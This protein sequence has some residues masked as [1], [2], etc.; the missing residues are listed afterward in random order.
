MNAT[1]LYIHVPFCSGKCSYCDFFSVPFRSDLGQVYL[2]ALDRE[3]QLV[4]DQFFG[5]QK[6]PVET[7]YLGGGTP[8]SLG[9]HDLAEL[10]RIIR[11]H[12]VP[13][14]ECEFTSEA[15]P[16]S[17]TTGKVR[18]LKAAGMNRLSIGAQTF[19]DAL[20][21]AIGR[22]HTSQQTLWAM[23]FA[24]EQEIGNVSLDLIYALPGQSREQFVN[25]LEIAVRLMPE[26]L[27][28]YELTYEPD[29][30]LAR[31]RAQTGEPEEE[32]RPVEM[33]CLADSRLAAAGFE[34]YEISNYAKPGFQC[35]HNLRY[36]QNLDYIGLGP[37]AAGF[38]N[39]RRY[40][41]TG[42]LGAYGDRLLKDNR[43][44]VASDEVLSARA[45][46]GE[47]AMLALRTRSGIGRQ[48]FLNRTGCDPFELFKA[49]I[50]KYAALGLLEVHA[51]RITLTMKGWT[52][53]NEV[54]ADF[55]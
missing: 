26:H 7:I 40:K 2:R 38:L 46:A 4:R 34:H 15:N 32:D 20:L 55:L 49:P 36:W 33:F 27:S 47:T 35:R 14:A 30:K 53:S 9:L 19:D 16:E 3:A 42:D 21:K 43:L 18:E 13:T 52:L 22:R 23:E 39:R 10:G 28:C 12:F 29:T 11:A 24:M 17:L 48:E 6:P 8:T 37:S 50:D 51:D 45:F 25:D 54:A 41:N 31:A 1:G 44:P 5:G